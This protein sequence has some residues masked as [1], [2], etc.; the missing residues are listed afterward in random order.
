MEN[1]IIDTDFKKNKY[2]I[3]KNFISKELAFF[4]FSYLFIDQLPDHHTDH[5][6]KHQPMPYKNM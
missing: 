6:M 4:L 5:L 1:N 2:K 3:V